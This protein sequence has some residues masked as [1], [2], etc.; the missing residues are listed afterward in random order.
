MGEDADVTVELLIDAG[1]EEEVPDGVPAELEDGET[2]VRSEEHMPPVRRCGV[3]S[4]GFS[5]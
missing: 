4:A 2:E 1:L 5:S 3:E